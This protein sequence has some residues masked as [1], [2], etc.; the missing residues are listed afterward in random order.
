M[1][2]RSLGMLGSFGSENLKAVESHVT[3]S[4]DCY[5]VPALV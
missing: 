5:L 1:K 4:C 2:E 3:D